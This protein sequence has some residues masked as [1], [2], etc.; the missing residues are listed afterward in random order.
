MTTQLLSGFK[1]LAN[2]PDGEFFFILSDSPARAVAPAMSTPTPAAEQLKALGNA[3]YARGKFGAAVD[4][5]TDAVLLC[6]RWLPV[7][8]NRA[9]CHRKKTNWPLVKADCLKALDIDKESIKGNYMLGL[10]L[11]AEKDY[12]GAV[13][14]LQKALENARSNG[15]S[16]QDEIWR[17]LVS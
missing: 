15:A 13:R 10:S 16:I 11:I 8:L 4:A 6:P 14:R 12:R 2:F 7:I 17:E 5:Y 9:L 1:K 3:M